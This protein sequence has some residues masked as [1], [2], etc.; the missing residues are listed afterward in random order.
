M[1]KTS[2]NYNDVNMMSVQFSYCLCHLLSSVS[3]SSTHLSWVLLHL[4]VSLRSRYSSRNEVENNPNNINRRHDPEKAAIEWSQIVHAPQAKHVISG[5][6][7]G[8]T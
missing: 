4:L 3:A 8:V 2:A 5:R 7:F 1:S 6:G